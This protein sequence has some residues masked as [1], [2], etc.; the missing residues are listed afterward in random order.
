MLHRDIKPSNI[1]LG[2]DD[3]AYLID[4]GIAR[5][6]DETRMTKSGNTIGTFAYIAPERLDPGTEEDARADIYSLACVLYEALTGEPPFAGNTTAHLIAAHLNTPPPRPSTTQPDVPPQ[7]DEVI[8]TGM[9]KDPDQRY[10]TTVELADAAHDAITTPLSRP[11]PTPT[12][13]PTQPA[14]SPVAAPA[15]GHEARRHPAPEPTLPEDHPATP[16]NA[17]AR[18]ASGQ[19]RAPQVASP[20]PPSTPPRARGWRRKMT[21]RRAMVLAVPALL[22]LAAIVFAGITGRLYLA[23]RAAADA[24]QAVVRTAAEAVNTLW[25]YTPEDMDGLPDRAAKYL[26]GDFRDQYAQFVK[27]IVTPNKQAKITNKTQV[28]AAGIES[29]SGSEATA[30]VYTNTTSTSPTT[31]PQVKYLSYRLVMQMHDSA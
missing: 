29:F 21:R 4:F 11:T 16:R 7:V 14:P 28:L 13:P 24:K 8:A 9:A 3:F 30:I 17:G 5:A 23:D 25:T 22:C 27:A 1:L 31:Q 15:F 20:S 26:S 12:Q 10:A 6:A 18:Q 19:Q 2:R